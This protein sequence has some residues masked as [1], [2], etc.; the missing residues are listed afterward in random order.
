[1]YKNTKSTSR[2][3]IARRQPSEKA[4]LEKLYEHSKTIFVGRGIVSDKSF[5]E[6]PNSHPKALI[7]SNI[8]YLTKIGYLETQV[9]E[10]P[11]WFLF[12]PRI[13]LLIRCL[14]DTARFNR[15]AIPFELEVIAFS[16]P[17]NKKQAINTED[18]N[19]A[20]KPKNIKV[21][22]DESIK[23]VF[24]IAFESAKKNK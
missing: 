22:K 16:D 14:K 9:S 10:M 18:K 19:I 20:P 3:S 8:K 1:M 2:S 21:F 6:M 13:S 23:T 4:Y 5:G 11:D 15:I 24:E 17:P 12:H 7:T